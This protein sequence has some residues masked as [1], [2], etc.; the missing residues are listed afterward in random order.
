MAGAILAFVGQ[1]ATLQSWRFRRGLGGHSAAGGW[2][3]A[4]WAGAAAAVLWRPVRFRNL[5]GRFRRGACLRAAARFRRGI[6]CAKSPGGGSWAAK[7]RPATAA[8][9]CSNDWAANSR[10][11]NNRP[12][13]RCRNRAGTTGR[14]IVAAAIALSQNLICRW[15]R[16]RRRAIRAETWAAAGGALFNRCASIQCCV[17][18]ISAIGCF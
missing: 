14:N 15:A 13:T 5:L 4:G 1:R 8:A 10:R 17:V 16:R 6:Q 3:I 7:C 2:G 18:C 12:A 9:G 11:A